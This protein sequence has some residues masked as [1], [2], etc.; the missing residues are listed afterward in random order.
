[1]S[2]DSGRE[3]RLKCDQSRKAR[4]VAF[5]SMKSRLFSRMTSLVRVGMIR[6][7]MSLVRCCSCHYRL[8]RTIYIRQLGQ[9]T[10]VKCTSHSS[11]STTT[12]LNGQA[13][14]HLTKSWRLLSSSAHSLYTIAN[15]SHLTFC[16]S[17]L[18]TN[19]W[20]IVP[21]ISTRKH[22]RAALVKKHVQPD[23][24]I[25]DFNMRLIMNHTQTGTNGLI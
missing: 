12:S 13:V 20:H 4:K 2:K 11:L 9:I 10:I 22:G 1:M 21:Q 3:R 5:Q 24:L 16:S 6:R 8:L 17:S 19:V 25:I 14:L 7:V 18:I 15:S 23:H